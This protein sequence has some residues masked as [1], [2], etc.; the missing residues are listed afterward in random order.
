MC[1]SSKSSLKCRQLGFYYLANFYR[2]VAGDFMDIMYRAPWIRVPLVI[3][4]FYV[5]ILFFYTWKKQRVSARI[6]YTHF[7]W[8]IYSI[9]LTY[10]L[11]FRQTL[12]AWLVRKIGGGQPSAGPGSVQ[13]QDIQRVEMSALPTEPGLQPAQ[14]YSDGVSAYDGDDLPLSF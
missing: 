14:L 6:L 9:L 2:L 7:Y 12:Q 3:V 8:N 10:F 13:S 1:L 11:Y 4:L 5:S